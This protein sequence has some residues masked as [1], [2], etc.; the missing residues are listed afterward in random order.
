MPTRLPHLLT[1]S[2]LLTSAVYAQPTPDEAPPEGSPPELLKPVQSDALGQLNLPPLWDPTDID[3]G[4][5]AIEGQTSRPGAIEIVLVPLPEKLPADALLQ[6]YLDEVRS[7]HPE[8]TTEPI[9][10][11]DNGKLE[12]R[13]AQLRLREG[14]TPMRYAVVVVSGRTGAYFATLGAPEDRFE[15]LFPEELLVNVLNSIQAP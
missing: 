3:G 9:H 14:D 5:R 6:A 8:A 15:A 2:L 7:A 4:L 10:P 12:T 1:L 11:L 13:A